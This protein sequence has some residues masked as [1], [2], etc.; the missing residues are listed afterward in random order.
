MYLQTV[1]TGF[2]FGEGTGLLD[3]AEL[4]SWDEDWSI[5]LKGKCMSSN[6]FVTPFLKSVASCSKWK[7]S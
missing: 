1:G 4:L 5:N 3:S 2:L 6:E 7:V